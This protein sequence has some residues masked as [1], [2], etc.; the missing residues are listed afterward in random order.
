MASLPSY[1]NFS[2]FASSGHL[3]LLNDGNFLAVW[4]EV[5]ESRVGTVF[6]QVFRPDGTTLKSKFTIASAAESDF[7]E[8]AAAT[9]TDGRTIVSW[10]AST[11]DGRLIR[12]QALDANH[13]V[14]GDPLPLGPVSVGSQANSHIFALADGSFSVLYEGTYEGE[15]LRV[16]SVV[17]EVIG[18]WDY[19]DTFYRGFGAAPSNSMAVSGNGTSAYFE[20]RPNGFNTGLVAYIWAPGVES[21]PGVVV[22]EIAGFTNVHPSVAPIGADT[23]VAAW[24]DNGN[25]G[26]HVIHAQVFDSAGAA[27]GDQITFNKPA[28]TLEDTP[29]ITALSSGGFAIAFKLDV[30]GDD[31]V[32]VAACAAD[33]TLIADVTPVG[34]STA[35]DQW[36]PSIIA[37]ADG[38]YA[39][40]WMNQDSSGFKLMTQLYGVAGSVTPDNPSSSG[41]EWVGT[42]GDDFHVGS[43]EADILFGG[44][45][46]DVLKGAAGNDAIFGEAGNDTLYG[47]DGRDTMTGGSG[48]DIFVF[49]SAVSKKNPNVDKIIDFNVKDDSIWLENAV[50]KA[51][52]KKGSAAKPAKLSKDAFWVGSKAHDASDR[53][54]YD[55]KKGI[56]YYDADGTGSKAA[57]QIATFSKKYPL[58]TYKDF[59]IV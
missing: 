49:D 32:Y 29:V 10:T 40:S 2:A 54:I 3:T 7:T 44:A 36:A 23:F 12:G 50:F 39:V 56:L 53:I 28:G 18:G 30:S 58:L 47:G 31:N 57:Y 14:V 21:P 41:G 42:P 46:N 59:F 19:V 33:G 25:G 27:V 9:L 37:L 51:L 26:T 52:G 48:K 43:A 38:N 17:R 13:N 34:A 35:G 11:N 55:S 6:G 22:D 8:V 45:G 24:E 4:T 15:A 16:G 5:N 20:A 1:Q